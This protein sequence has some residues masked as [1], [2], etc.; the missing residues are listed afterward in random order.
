MRPGVLPGKETISS[1]WE[2]VDCDTV[3]QYVAVIDRDAQDPMRQMGTVAS[4]WRIG[5]SFLTLD[6]FSL[7]RSSERP[8]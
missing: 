4:I 3:G 1:P 8:S 7:E 6:R 2:N 5:V